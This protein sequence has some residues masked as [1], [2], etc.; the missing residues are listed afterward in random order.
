[1]AGF[2]THTIGATIV[3]AL[4]YA[5]MIG[6][7][8]V[9]QSHAL[10]QLLHKPGML[11]SCAGILIL[12]SLWPDIDTNSMSQDIFYLSFFIVDLGL[13]VLEMYVASAYLGLAALVP[14]MGK[15][16]GWTHSRLACVLI[17][18]P[19]VV[20]P[21]VIHQEVDLVGVPYY[22]SA[23]LGYATHLLLDRKWF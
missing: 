16:R 7:S 10:T 21:M 12:F 23:V 1:M 6:L 18:L 17:P 20:L 11:L 4:S 13:I 22:V 15:H 9:V 2:K 19:M 5:A 3:V 14:I 8:S